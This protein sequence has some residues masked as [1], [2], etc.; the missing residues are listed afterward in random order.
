MKK[1]TSSKCVNYLK[2]HLMNKCSKI[3]LIINQYT[4]FNKEITHVF[5]IQ[6]YNQ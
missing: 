5:K 3:P 6:L 1:S 4:N 2:T